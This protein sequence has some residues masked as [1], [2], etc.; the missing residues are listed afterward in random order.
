MTDFLTIFDLLC[1]VRVFAVWRIKTKHCPGSSLQLNEHA[2]N[3]F[4]DLA[5]EAKYGEADHTSKRMYVATAAGSLFQINYATRALECIYKL[6]SGPIYSLS[7]NEGFC[8]TGSGDCFLRVWPLDFSDYFLQ[9]QH[10]GAISAVQ[11]SSDGLH[12]LVGSENGCIGVMDL[13]STA[14]QTRIRSHLDT[15]YGVAFDPHRDEFCTVSKDG[16]IRVFGAHSLEQIYEFYG[17]HES[18]HC[19]AYHP[20][21]SEYRVACGFS[22][23]SVRV[24]DIATTTMHVD[25]QQHTGRVLDVL[26][27]NDGCFLY[28]AG[29]DG[30]V[31]A[32][33]V[34]KNYLPIRMFTTSGHTNHK[35]EAE[36][37]TA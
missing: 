4:T 18:V 10:K 30:N 20:L 26:F 8:V 22:S 11:I 9:A 3:T 6:H 25:Y 19:V 2:R 29:E 32:Y 23:G 33:D 7:V 5:F 13:S 34:H 16:T 31:C 35:S 1:R 28:S 12:V 27:S 36:D 15:I 21:E 17:P 14:Y 37:R 24:M